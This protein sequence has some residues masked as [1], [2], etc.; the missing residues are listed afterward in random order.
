MKTGKEFSPVER[1]K[2]LVM[3]GGCEDCHSPKIFTA[4]GPIPDST[5]RLFGHPA[6]TQLPEIPKGI[7]GPTSLGASTT[8]DQ[9]A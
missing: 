4:A 5:R 2:Y 1:G 3:V 7:L 9:T 6:G 8:P